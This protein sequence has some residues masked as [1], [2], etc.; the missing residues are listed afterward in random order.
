MNNKRLASGVLTVLGL[1]TTGA[2]AAMLQA[3]D[4]LNIDA[5]VQVYDGSGY[6]ID[7]SSGSYFALD[8]S[9]I[10]SISDA[11]KTAII[12]GVDGGIRAGYT[13]SP[14]EIDNTLWLGNSFPHYTTVA[15]TGG[16]TSGL[17]FSGWSLMEWNMVPAA[18]GSGAWTPLN[19]A[20]EGVACSGYA[21][22]VAV[23]NWSG[24]YGDAYTLDYTAR[25]PAS[26]SNFGYA[27]YFLHLEGVVT[28]AVP[29]P[30]AAWLFGS[31]LLGL[32]NAGIR[33]RVA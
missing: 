24:I 25:F 28:S 23:F 19:C 2:Q 5:G 12:P 27:R 30:A 20:T 16:T 31:G 1:A 3:G 9:N 4:L 6:Q 32:L 18:L 29:V 33:R 26:D 10:M 14:G 21:D 11:W 15:V 8:S 13:Q 7:V 17:D 22:G